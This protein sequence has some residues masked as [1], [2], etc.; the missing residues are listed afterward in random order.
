M[1]LN[2]TCF[3]RLTNDERFLM[4]LFK[5]TGKYDLS[6]VGSS[7][8][9]NAKFISRVLREEAQ[10]AAP[11]SSANALKTPQRPNRR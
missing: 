4:D 9:K 10:P 5:Q 7:L 11:D 2:M 1:L 3:K 6:I 8:K